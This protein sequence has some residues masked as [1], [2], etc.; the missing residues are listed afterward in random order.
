[1]NIEELCDYAILSTWTKSLSY[2][3]STLLNLRYILHSFA[4]AKVGPTQYYEGVP[5]K[6]IS[7]CKSLVKSD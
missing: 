7:G 5:D 4:W 3:S 2:G 1:M 6:V